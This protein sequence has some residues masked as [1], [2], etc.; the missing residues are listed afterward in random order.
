[1]IVWTREQILE[2][3]V[4]QIADDGI[5]S[6]REAGKLVEGWDAVPYEV[7]G[8]LHGAAMLNGSEIHFAMR[9]EWRGKSITRRRAR[10]FLRPL[11]DRLGFLTTRVEVGLDDAFV[12]R[13][14]FTP[15]WSDG[16]FQFYMMTREP[17]AKKEMTCHQ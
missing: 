1:M 9:P 3:L 5:I 16:T 17:F 4:E 15:T 7:D 10:E 8:V 13:I 12:R 6:T 2:P 14:G 11:L